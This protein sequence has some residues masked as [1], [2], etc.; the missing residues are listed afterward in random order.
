MD[1]KG[2][3]PDIFTDVFVY[4]IFVLVIVLFLSVLVLSKGCSGPSEQNIESRISE[5]PYANTFLLNLLR[6][7]VEVDG[8]SMAFADLII[9]DME[10]GDFDRSE[11]F[12]SPILERYGLPNKQ[13]YLSVSGGE[14]VIFYQGGRLSS[15]ALAEGMFPGA[16]QSVW[17]P[18]ADRGDPVNVRLYML[19]IY[20]C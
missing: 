20:D 9:L 7:P 1:R 16:S 3:I 19:C 4:M 11:G 8:E 17:L 5:V 13:W 10:E 14:N 2:T 6:S 18:S 15:T 12:V